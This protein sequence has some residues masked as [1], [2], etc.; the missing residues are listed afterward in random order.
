L[1]TAEFIVQGFTEN[2]DHYIKITEL[3]SD[4]H[5]IRAIFSVAFVKTSGIK[6][7]NEALGRLKDKVTIFAGIRN[8]VTSIQSIFKLIDLGLSVYLV[9]TGSSNITYHPKL[10]V[11]ECIDYYK[12]IIG[13][14]NLTGGGLNTN[15][16][17]SSILKFRKEDDQIYALVSNIGLLPEKYK[18]NIFKIHNKKEAF[19]FYKQGL[20][21]DERITANTTGNSKNMLINLPDQTPRIKLK[22]RKNSMTAEK[23]DKKFKGLMPLMSDIVTQWA[24]AWESNKL[25]ERDLNIP[26]TDGTNPTGSMLLKKGKFKGIDQRVYFRNEVFFGLD[27]IRDTTPETRH[28]E[29]TSAQFQLEIRGL[30]YGIY[31]LKLSH[32]TNTESESY[33]QKNSMTQVHWGSEVKKLIAHRELLGET[34]EL[35]RSASNPPVFRIKIG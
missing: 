15:I 20:L 25:T 32:N 5:L 10:Y 6:L 33:K 16:E 22:N 19:L 35:Y 11:F 30:N 24:L 4:C 14:A 1:E 21:I 7:L 9:D 18:D 31:T 23:Y 27:W 3:L 8:G 17:F 2:N 26:S 34:M 13:S 28:Y 12:I 29:R